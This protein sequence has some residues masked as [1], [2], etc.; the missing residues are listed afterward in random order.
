MAII[1]N[2]I[3]FGSGFNITAEGPIDSR[4]VVEYISDLTTV[5]NSDAPAYEGM[6]V[7]V[8]EDGNVYTLIDSDFTD[9][10]NW[11]KQGGGI[12]IYSSVDELPEDVPT[13]TLASVL[14]KVEKTELLPV[15]KVYISGGKVSGLTIVYPETADIGDFNI[16]STVNNLGLNFSNTN[17]N[18]GVIGVAN[19]SGKNAIIG[20]DGSSM[21]S[22]LVEYDSDGNLKSVNQSFI[23]T[24]MRNVTTYRTISGR[25]VLD[26]YIFAN[27]ISTTYNSDL[28]VKTDEGWRQIKELVDNSVT[29]EKISNGSVT[30][31]KLSPELQTSM[32]KV[33][34]F[35]DASAQSDEIIDTLKEIQEY[36]ESDESGAA[37]MV[38]SIAST[39]DDVEQLK[40][41]VVVL[42]EEEYK[43]LLSDGTI[44][45][46]TI[47]IVKFE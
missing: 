36:I 44:N 34:T 39:K 4:M 12:E 26:K 42:T 31:D 38:E 17:V 16:D 43:N 29:T 45:E 46:E 10:N 8:I 37:A 47:Y 18:R 7:S 25:N 2:S 27:G 33:S 5:W 30:I 20:T 21:P 6:I 1:K 15:S 13:G 40:Q 23:D 19:Y 22:V 41:S 9:I 32:S 11:K 3:T 28:Y 24:L 35:L 14:Y